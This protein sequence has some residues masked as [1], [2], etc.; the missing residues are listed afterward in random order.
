MSN[1]R[2]DEYGGSVENRARFP[3][4][5]L[6]AVCAAVGPSRV[7]VRL[8]PYSPW[9]GMGMPQADVDETF[10]YYVR[11]V[12]E[13]HAD[14]AYLH[15]VT[16]RMAGIL[17]VEGVKAEQSLDF[18]VRP[19]LA[20][21]HARRCSELMMP[22]LQRDLWSPRPLI[23]AGGFDTESARVAADS[24]ENT[25]IAMGRYYIANPDLPRRVRERIPFTPYERDLFYQNGPDKVHGYTDYPFAP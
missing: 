12:R 15:C 16:A 21:V 10:G 9:Q 25:L 23:L 17:D 6:D 19:P 22:S 7:G 4:E 11:Q 5:V 18:I 14:L 13:R 3:L 24:G 1:K 2:T 20:L 8:S